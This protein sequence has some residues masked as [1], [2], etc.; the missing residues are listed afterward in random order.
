MNSMD[1]YSTVSL[2]NK[3]SKK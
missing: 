3:I 1:M 2:A